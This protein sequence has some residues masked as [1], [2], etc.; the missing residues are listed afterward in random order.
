MIVA[1]L[2]IGTNSVKLVVAD[3]D[4]IVRDAVRI[5]KL[6]EGID[7]SGQLNEAA[8]ERT[9]AAIREFA[10]LADQHHATVRGGVGTSAL[11]DAGESGKAFA[12]QASDIFGGPIEV[13]S[14][15]R[16]AELTFF[17]GFKAAPNP[18]GKVIVT[19]IGGGSAEVSIGDAS[20]IQFSTSLQM[21]AVRLTERVHPADPWLK[22]DV[23][24]AITLADEA[25]RTLPPPGEFG[26]ISAFVACGGTAANLAGMALAV[27]GEEVNVDTVHQTELHDHTLHVQI[28]NLAFQPLS[29]RRKVAGLEPE[30]AEVI[31]AGAILQRALLKH[32][33]LDSLIV[34]AQGL[35]YGVL[36]ALQQGQKL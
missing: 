33:H 8:I 11:R 25:A 6:G 4:E 14:G 31:V 3:G 30:R 1:A 21:G 7:A 2:D 35:R 5:T 20:G 19:D 13:I 29:A 15:E 26:E 9:L 24:R 10:A 36:H 34:S 32:F 22:E 28:E 16:E 23:K 27:V 17:A 18:E 12:R